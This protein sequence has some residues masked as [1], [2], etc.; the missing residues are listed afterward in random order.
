M[1]SLLV[2]RLEV[3]SKLPGLTIFQEAS[4][5]ELEGGA[6]NSMVANIAEA[7]WR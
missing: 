5:N 6:R 3:W 4:Y 1:F 2:S 7:L